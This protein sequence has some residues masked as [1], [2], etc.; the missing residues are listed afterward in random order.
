MLSLSLYCTPHQ[1][2]DI[3][4]TSRG[5]H[6][7][8]RRKQTIVPYAANDSVKYLSVKLGGWGK[9]KAFLFFFLREI[10]FLMFFS[11]ESTRTREEGRNRERGRHRIGSRLQAP[12]CQRRA[13]RGAR[14]HGLRDHDLSRSRTLNRR[15]S[16]PGA[17]KRAC[18]KRISAASVGKQQGVRGGWPGTQEPG[19]EQSGASVQ[20]WARAFPSLSL[21][22]PTYGVGLTAGPSTLGH[23]VDEMKSLDHSGWQDGWPRCPRRNL[24]NPRL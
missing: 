9:E 7:A 14:T 1:T 20:P 12:S 17:P 24:Q 3:H 15:R 21:S 2:T 6:S 18:L 19:K 4:G 5:D 11:R 22:F 16:R 10:F 13:R 8:A 23:G